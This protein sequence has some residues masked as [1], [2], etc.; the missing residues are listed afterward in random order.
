MC[1]VGDE[2]EKEKKK[3]GIWLKRSS[4]EVV[5][6]SSMCSFLMVTAGKVALRL[7][8]MRAVSLSP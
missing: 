8:C 2:K 3:Q 1:N 4:S 6:S 5:P 7:M